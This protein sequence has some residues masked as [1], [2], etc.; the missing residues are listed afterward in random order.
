MSGKQAPCLTAND[1]PLSA[2]RDHRIMFL[3]G[4]EGSMVVVTDTLRADV[5]VKLTRTLGFLV[6]VEDIDTCGVPAAQEAYPTIMNICRAVES[7]VAAS[8]PIDLQTEGTDSSLSP[9]TRKVP[10][11]A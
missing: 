10:K 1:L 8:V 7:E 2:V 3:R 6:T 11:R 4:G 9:R 5:G